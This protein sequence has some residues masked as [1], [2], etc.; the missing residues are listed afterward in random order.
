[1][2]NQ[3]FHKFVIG[4][5]LFSLFGFL[6]F[7][8]C[9]DGGEDNIT[10]ATTGTVNGTLRLPSEANGKPWVVMVDND[11]NGD[12]GCVC[13]ATGT[14]AAGSTIS[15]SVSNVPPGTY[16]LYAVVFVTSDG[17]EGPQFGDFWGIYGGE[18]PDN[19]PSTPNANISSGTQTFDIN[20]M[21]RQGE[22]VSGTWNAT[23]GFGGFDFIVNSEATYITK[24]KLTFDNWRIG[25]HTLN[26][27][28]TISYTTGPGWQI[29][30][31]QFSFVSDLAPYPSTGHIMTISGSFHANGSEASGT[32][33]A[34]FDGSTDSG[35]WQA[36]PEGE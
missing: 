21:V 19:V 28:I 6:N 3:L 18:F 35:T 5:I 4:C 33:H 8:S 25:N 13:S 24:F 29:T 32:W 15:Y 27:S 12:N 26:G 2:K 16:F 7:I 14:C 23:S 30:D 11:T 1:M 22:I 9:S 20:L 17:T 34:D 10:N 31:R 36:S